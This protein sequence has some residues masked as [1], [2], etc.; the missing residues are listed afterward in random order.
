MAA[1]V[2]VHVRDTGRKAALYS[3]VPDP[4][5][6]PRSEVWVVIQTLR[7]LSYENTL[8]IYVDASYA[9]NGVRVP[10][11]HY[12]EV[13]NGDLWTR[14]HKLSLR[15]GGKVIFHKVESHVTSEEGRTQY[16]MTPEG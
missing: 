5:T 4:Q 16:G 15:F 13:K 11:K 1:G 12:L 9:I 7:R 8:K 14:I 3:R 10:A 6:V 2:V